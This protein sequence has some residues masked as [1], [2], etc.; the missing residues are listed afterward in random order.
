MYVYWHIILM[1]Y[2]CVECPEPPTSIFGGG[3]VETCSDNSDC[4]NG[5]ICCSNGCGHECM[6]PA[7]DP[8]AVSVRI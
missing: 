6:T 5:Q 3:C 8:C 4:T 2:V 7:V 1:L